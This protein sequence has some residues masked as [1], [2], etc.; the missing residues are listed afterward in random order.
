M[1][2]VCEADGDAMINV[3]EADADVRDT[4]CKPP[5]TVGPM[6]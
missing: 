4:F 3:C 6:P 1:I 5:L 2:N